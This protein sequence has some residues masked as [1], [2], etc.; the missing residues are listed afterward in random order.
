MYYMPCLNSSVRRQPNI[1]LSIVCDKILSS[2]CYIICN[3]RI[4]IKKGENAT[5]FPSIKQE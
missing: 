2:F 3:G 1:Q 4:Q 5:I